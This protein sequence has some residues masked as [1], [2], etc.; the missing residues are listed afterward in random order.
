MT[1][2]GIR[3]TRQGLYCLLWWVLSFPA[4]GC[5]LFDHE[6]DDVVIVIGSTR[7]T[8][9]TL[10]KEM[11]FMSGGLPLPGNHTEEIKNQLIRQIIDYY[12]IIEHGKENGISVSES[13]FQKNLADIKK[14]YTEK[15]FR[16]ALV[17][18]Y[19]DP[20]LWERRLRNQ[21]L[22]NKVIKQA[23]ERIASPSYEEI[24]RYFQENRD[25]FRTPE[26]LKFRQ[27]VCKSKEDARKLRRRL[28]AG[29]D[30]GILAAKY[31][32][33]PEADNNGEVGW[34]AR[35]DLDKSMED[36]LFSMQSGEI[37]PVVKTAFG[38]HLLEVMSRRPAG[39]KGL[40]EV[41]DGIESKLRQQKHESFYKKW[42]KKLR[43]DFKVKV[44]QDMLNK[45]ELS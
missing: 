15:A 41:I 11:E 20:E 33:A 2:K 17:K 30:M 39:V 37:S 19:V 18:E 14:G 26:M 44:N 7:L 24:K 13:E 27:I 45:L 10:R 16:Q 1:K 40:P 34:V 28:Q 3:F 32:I 6:T 29:E 4:L 38:Y 12:L 22:V 36:A 31:S 42:L 9:D 25:K 8:K 35:G 43:A 23:S 21:I 5:N